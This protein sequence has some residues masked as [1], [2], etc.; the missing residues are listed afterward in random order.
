MKKTWINFKCTLLSE[1]SQSEK[2]TYYTIPTIWHSG[3][4]ETFYMTG[5]EGDNKKLSSC[6]GLGNER[7]E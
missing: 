6:Q 1:R 2:A 7:G 5:W 3:K 4:G